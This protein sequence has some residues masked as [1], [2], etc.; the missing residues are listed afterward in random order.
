MHQNKCNIYVH[1]YSGGTEGES[2]GVEREREKGGEREREIQTRTRTHAHTSTRTKSYPNPHKLLHTYRPGAPGTRSN[3]GGASARAARFPCF[4]RGRSG[5]RSQPSRPMRRPPLL[6]LR[7][8][9]RLR[10]R[11]RL[12]M[13]PYTHNTSQHKHSTVRSKSA[14]CRVVQRIRIRI[15]LIWIHEPVVPGRSGPSKTFLP[16]L[17]SR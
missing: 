7:L 10:P 5:R 4:H 1:T 11:L 9:L 3:W 6:R 14:A 2:E 12:D 16:P 13:L 15:V 8:R 17:G